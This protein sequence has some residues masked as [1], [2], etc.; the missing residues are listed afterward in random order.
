MGR[1]RHWWVVAGVVVVALG[2]AIAELAVDDG[3]G[4]AVKA[5]VAGALAALV[6][7]LALSLP[8][9]S[10]RGLVLGAFFIGSGIAS[11]VFMDQ[12]K[13]VWAILLVQGVVCL[14][15]G[16]PYMTHL[17]DGVKLGT[18]W[19]GV[20]YWVFGVIGA[21]L[22]FDIGVTA[23]RVAYAGIAGLA[24][25][26]AVGLVRR[27]GVDLSV[28][29]TA[30]FLLAIAAL[31]LSG[32]GNLFESV[33]TV[34]PGKWGES[35][36]YR[37][38]GGEYLLYHPNALAGLAAMVAIRIGPDKA[39]QVWQRL[40]VI[41]LAGFMVYA[42]NSRTAF[43]ILAVGGILH[44]AL[45]WW[46]RRH[47]VPGLP[48]Y[49]D[50]RRTLAAAAVPFV[51]L[52]LVLVASGGQ[53]FIFKE[54]YGSGGVT[55]GRVDTWKFVWK[56]WKAAPVVDKVFGDTKTAR[57]VV[58]RPGAE[59]LLL[60]TDSSAV[61]SLRRGGVLGVV[62]FLVGLVLLLWHGLAWVIRRG[63]PAR[64]EARASGRAWFAI[65]VVAA[66]P[67][68]AL[69]DWLLGGTGGTFWVL[70][71]TGEAFLLVK[72]R[73]VASQETVSV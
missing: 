34:P 47:D 31:L 21:L 69:N 52:A 26:A 8:G 66:I 2:A 14:K 33:H 48:D 6:A 10:W 68:M 60:P 32:S 50:T 55:S 73:Q 4:S 65:A 67:T 16:W 53:G 28:G 61:G 71:L 54:R 36:E 35:F 13:V 29:V 3:F 58:E 44:A 42:T 63:P 43:V 9:V 24:V 15:W 18:T 72:K 23:Q 20:A 62:A 17:K 41:A 22:V 19:L 12:P 11:W 37:F 70:L 64:A 49:G 7:V 27:T 56:E 5:F 30:A 25:A 45:L 1:I 40:A 57:A 46:R 39:F 51:V 38:W 59:G